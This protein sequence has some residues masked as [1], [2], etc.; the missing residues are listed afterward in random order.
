[1]ICVI[2]ASGCERHQ[3]ELH[4][5]VSEGMEVS[6]VLCRLCFTGV[7]HYGYIIELLAAVMLHGIYHMPGISSSAC[8]KCLVFNL[9][10]FIFYKLY[11]WDDFIPPLLHWISSSWSFGIPRGAVAAAVKLYARDVRHLKR[12]RRQ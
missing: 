7:L 6:R 5:G 3:W 8:L 2:D 10:I 1:M 4:I 9:K 11:W 12:R